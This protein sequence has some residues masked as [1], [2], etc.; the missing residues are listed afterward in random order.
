MH[1]LASRHN[2]T[3]ATQVADGPTT[4]THRHWLECASARG[5]CRIDGKMR[6]RSG[7]PCAERTA[8]RHESI[9]MKIEREFSVWAMTR[10]SRDLFIPTL[11][12]SFPCYVHSCTLLVLV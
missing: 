10:T 1:T 2:S 5:F 12:V 11:S 4:A 9:R 8:N 3:P 6:G 7:P